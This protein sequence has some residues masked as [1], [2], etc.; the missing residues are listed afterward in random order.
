MKTGTTG[1]KRTLS[2]LF[3]N[4]LSKGNTVNILEKKQRHDEILTD[5]VGN[6]YSGIE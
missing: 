1:T 6:F 2:H 5:V 3:K 4:P